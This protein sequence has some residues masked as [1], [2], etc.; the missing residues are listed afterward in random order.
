MASLIGNYPQQRTIDIYRLFL[1]G[2]SQTRYFIIL[3]YFEILIVFHEVHYS[4]SYL[5]LETI[6]QYFGAISK[7]D[8]FSKGKLKLKD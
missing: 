4:G 3:C 2:L 6:I 1:G 8:S 5:K 7:T